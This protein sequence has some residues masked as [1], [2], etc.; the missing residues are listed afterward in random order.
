MNRLLAAAAL[1]AFLLP[2]SASADPG[3]PPERVVTV[4]V[5]GNDPCPK[6]TGDE[7][8]VCP[9]LPESD[10]Y[11][12]PKRFR[13]KKA[14]ERAAASAWANRVETLESVSRAGTPN[15]CSPVGSGGFTGCYAKL[16]ADARAER[17]QAKTEAADVP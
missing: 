1:A 16:L 11:R 2:V 10:R 14:S 3:D 5:F 12:I 9:R 17:R 6:A 15:S 4:T 13:G 7:I 8:V